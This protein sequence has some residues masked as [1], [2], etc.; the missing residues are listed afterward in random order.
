MAQIRQKKLTEWDNKLQ[1]QSQ[2]IQITFWV[3]RQYVCDYGNKWFYCI[4]R[5]HRDK[6]GTKPQVWLITS[7]GSL[8]DA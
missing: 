4:Y 6:N 8:A 3:N 7:H 1:K 5:I 2:Q